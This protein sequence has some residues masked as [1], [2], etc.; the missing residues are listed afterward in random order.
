MVRCD[1]AHS[2]PIVDII[3][4]NLKS[5]LDYLDVFLFLSSFYLLN[6]KLYITMI[7]SHDMKYQ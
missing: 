6:S 2:T 7:F 5:C 1:T 4:A 3:E